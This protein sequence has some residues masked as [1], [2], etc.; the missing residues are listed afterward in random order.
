MNMNLTNDERFYTDIVAAVTSLQDRPQDLQIW[1]GQFYAQLMRELKGEQL[2]EVAS[3]AIIL[4]EGMTEAHPEQGEDLENLPTEELEV[5]LHDLGAI[6][7][8]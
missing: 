7:N 4:V 3:N 5:V 2:R 1:R 8:E 6:V